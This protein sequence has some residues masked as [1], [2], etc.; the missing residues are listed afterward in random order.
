MEAKDSRERIFEKAEDLGRLLSQTA[1]YGYLKAARREIDADREATETLNRMRE[2]QGRLVSYVERGESPPAELQT[3]FAELQE[4]MQ[5]SSRFQAW[6]S[7]QANFEKL[8]DRV[9]RAI[10]R[11]IQRGDESRIIIPS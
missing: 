8:M 11:G 1:E 5:Q 4:E 2:L 3:E 10:D 7:A 9:N 6:I